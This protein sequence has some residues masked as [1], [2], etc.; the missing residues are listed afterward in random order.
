MITIT[1]NFEFSSNDFF[2]YLDQ[3]LITAIKTARNNDMPVK[4]ASGTKYNQNGIDTEITKYKRGEVYEAD[5]QNDRFHIVISY[6]T[7]DTPDGVVI[8]FSE[9]IKSYDEN[10]HG[11][12]SNLLYNLQLKWGAKKELKKMAQGVREYKN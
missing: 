10:S 7:K 2:N 8:T 3:Q 12:I 11:W 4:L 9:D 1:Q 5:F 6:Q